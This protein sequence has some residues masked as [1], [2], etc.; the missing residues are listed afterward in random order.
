M[1]NNLTPLRQ[2]LTFNSL[3]MHPIMN[4]N[5]D[6]FNCLIKLNL[7]NTDNNNFDEQIFGPQITFHYRA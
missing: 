3:K 4:W 7:F 1:V 5:T 2:K 6:I